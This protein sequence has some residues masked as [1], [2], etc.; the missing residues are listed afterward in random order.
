MTIL[1]LIFKR[2][3]AIIYKLVEITLIELTLKLLSTFAPNQARYPVSQIRK[4]LD[5][6]N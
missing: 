4:H 5:Q 2:P 6:F 1:Q 3:V